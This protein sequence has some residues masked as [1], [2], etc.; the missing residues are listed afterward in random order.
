MSDDTQP[1]TIADA[2]ESTNTPSPNNMPKWIL[3]LVI[4][5]GGSGAGF[6]FVQSND[7]GEKLA[8]LKAEVR[9]LSVL[10]ESM[11]NGAKRDID[12][13]T[14]DIGR[15]RSEINELE[16]RLRSVETGPR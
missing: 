16:N 4:A 2:V 9:A 15:L 13:N 11:S 12:R 8:G 6:S 3:V 14:E 5:F 7:V 1:L 10:M